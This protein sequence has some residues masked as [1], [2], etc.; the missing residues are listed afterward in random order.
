MDETLGG[1][2]EKPAKAICEHRFVTKRSNWR[3]SSWADN[4]R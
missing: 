4:E 2:R 1:V 3:T